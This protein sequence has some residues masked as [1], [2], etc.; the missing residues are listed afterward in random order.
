MMH[1]DMCMAADICEEAL[2][3]VP[4]AWLLVPA[5]TAHHMLTS[6]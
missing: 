6:R 3:Y 4:G 5:S 1:M 2:V